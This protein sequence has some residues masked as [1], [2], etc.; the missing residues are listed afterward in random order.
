MT[1]DDSKGDDSVSSP[2]AE[3]HQDTPE[4]TDAKGHPKV[5]ELEEALS[6]EKERSSLLHKG[7]TDKAAEVKRL[8]TALVGEEEEVKEEKVEESTKFT[9]DEKTLLKWEIKNQ[10][11]IDLVTEEYEKYRSEGVKEKIALRLALDDKGIT[12]SNIS[13]H[14]RQISAGQPAA[15]VDREPASDITPEERKRMEI[16]GYSE[17]TLVAHKKLQAERQ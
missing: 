12:K 1:T 13:E 2:D 10:D 17:E 16:F 3:G 6:Q 7:L 11:K 4:S 14:M 15:S 9:E 8:K 5:K